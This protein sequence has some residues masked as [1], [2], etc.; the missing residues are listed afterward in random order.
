MIDNNINFLHFG[1]IDIDKI[2]PL[3]IKYL[4][5]KED[6]IDFTKFGFLTSKEASQMPPLTSS[7][8]V[9]P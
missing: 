2:V 4:R 5:A 8:T 3:I 9:L 7:Q 1:T 6:D